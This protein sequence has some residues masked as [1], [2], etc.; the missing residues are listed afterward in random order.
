MIV[1]A[2]MV[3]VVLVVLVVLAA[4]VVLVAQAVMVLVTDQQMKRLGA[5]RFPAFVVKVLKTSDPVH[6][7]RDVW[8]LTF[9][10]GVCV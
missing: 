1:N 4:Q 10:D 8:G 2:G 7:R 3:L 5:E 9:I 6:L